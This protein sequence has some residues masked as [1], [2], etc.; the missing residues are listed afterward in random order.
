MKTRIITALSIVFFLV[1]VILVDKKALGIVIFLFS[2][3]AMREYIRCFEKMSCKPSKIILYA[4]TALLLVPVLKFSS[5]KTDSVMLAGGMYVLLLVLAILAVLKN[6]RYKIIDLAVT[7]FGILY[8]PFLFAFVTLIRLM[9]HGLYYIWII[10]IGSCVTDTFAYFVGLS[11][12]K[13]KLLPEVSPKKTIEGSIG[14]VIA[15]VLVMLLYG[16]YLISVNVMD[17]SLLYFGILGFVMAI[18]AQIGDLFASSIK[19][20]VGVKDYG[21]I[22]PGHGGILDRFDS[23]MFI[24]PMIY[25]YMRFLGGV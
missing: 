20:F 3:V 22:L 12:G 8:I 6:H 1:G 15:T 25:F 24:A 11:I 7:V 5:F 17:V 4:S 2:I 13:H 18:V 21:N 14:G 19:R 9:E 10:F 16:K 23:I